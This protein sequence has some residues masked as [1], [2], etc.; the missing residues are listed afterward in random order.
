[1]KKWL[2]FWV[3]SVT[4]DSYAIH[5]YLQ[6][7][8]NK[9]KDMIVTAFF[10]AVAAIFQSAGGFLPGIGYLISP[11]ATVPIVFSVVYSIRS[12]WMAYLLSIVLLMIIQPS[13]IIVFPFTTGLLGLGIGFGFVYLKKR[14][15]IIALAS[16]SLFFGINMLLYGFRFPILGPSVQSSP[17]VTNVVY[18]YIF[19]FL[20]CWFWVEMIIVCFRKY[21]NILE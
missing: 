12:G 8:S 1:M 14:I 7:T 21:R 10:G 11:L 20:Y 9:S 19:S 18:I 15:S 4:V 2:M 16:F 6:S 17:D 3:K 13:E 5:H